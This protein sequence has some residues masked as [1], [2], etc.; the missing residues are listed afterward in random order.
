MGRMK[1]HRASWDHHGSTMK[2]PWVG[3]QPGV[4]IGGGVQKL[5]G[6]GERFWFIRWAP[7]PSWC[8]NFRVNSR[9]LR[10]RWS[11]AGGVRSCRS[12]CATCRKSEELLSVMLHKRSLPRGG[13]K[14]M[15]GLQWMDCIG[16]HLGLRMGPRW[17]SCQALGSRRVFKA[18]GQLPQKPRSPGWSRAPRPRRS[19]HGPKNLCHPPWGWSVWSACE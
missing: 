16:L 3:Y 9:L 10:I 18:P 1:P 2:P 6:R 7:T 4:R 14:P 15:G 11:R 5:N 8:N 13:T 17:V 12:S 19:G